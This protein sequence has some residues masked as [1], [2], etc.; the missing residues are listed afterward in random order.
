MSIASEGLGCPNPTGLVT[1]Q[2]YCYSNDALLCTEDPCHPRTRQSQRQHGAHEGMTSLT[3]LP[4]GPGLSPRPQLLQRVSRAV[5][6]QKPCP[7]DLYSLGV[8]ESPLS[9]P[10]SVARDRPKATWKFPQPSPTFR[11]PILHPPCSREVSLV[12][13]WLQITLTFPT[14]HHK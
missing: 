8:T 2:L 12:T 10:C 11:V 3:H 13:E 14:G 4:T 1:A 5:S 7:E 6:L 9:N